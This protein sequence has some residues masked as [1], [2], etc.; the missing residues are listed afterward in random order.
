M[1]GPSMA[2]SRVQALRDHSTTTHTAYRILKDRNKE[3]RM[4]FKEGTHSMMEK[5]IASD[6][7]HNG[8]MLEDVMS[9]DL[10]TPI[11]LVRF[12]LSDPQGAAVDPIARPL[13]PD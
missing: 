11:T 13:V 4:M 6:P 10:F 2:F 8:R 12:M 5:D 9:S 3:E 1:G 7:I